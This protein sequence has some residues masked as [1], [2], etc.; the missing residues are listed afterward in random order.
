MWFT[1]NY[2]DTIIEA[3]LA[4]VGASKLVVKNEK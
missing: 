2:V 3:I 1:P 4:A